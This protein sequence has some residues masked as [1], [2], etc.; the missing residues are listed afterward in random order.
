MA[1]IDSIAQAEALAGRDVC[2]PAEE[3]APLEQGAYF[4]SDLLN[5]ELFDRATAR[6]VGI[7]TGLQ[8]FGGPPLLELKGERGQEILIPFA[9]SICVRIDIAAKRIDADIPEGLDS[10]NEA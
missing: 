3:R 7:V 10:L 5:C 8:E 1:G 6:R 2:V 9:K 4:E